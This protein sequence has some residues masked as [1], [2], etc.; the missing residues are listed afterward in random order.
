MSDSSPGSSNDSPNGEGTLLLLKIGESKKEFSKSRPIL[1]TLSN[2]ALAF[3]EIC[4]FPRF[5][6]Q[7]TNVRQHVAATQVATC[8]GP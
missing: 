4:N 2:Q 6:E 3:V 7:S 1:Q 5:P 8:P